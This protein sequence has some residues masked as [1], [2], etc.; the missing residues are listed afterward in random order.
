MHAF[1]R[2]MWLSCLIIFALVTVGV[3]PACAFISGKTTMMMEI[4]GPDGLMM[5]AVP[6]DK[7]ADA[8]QKASDSDQG[9]PH[10]QMPDCNYCI[11]QAQGKAITTPDA[12]II[13]FHFVYELKPLSVATFALSYAL[14]GR[15]PARGPPTIL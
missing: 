6:P 15:M 9:H 10:D 5:V 3:S 12:A 7:A 2:H 1:R 14:D 11:A 4:C 8:S 13:D